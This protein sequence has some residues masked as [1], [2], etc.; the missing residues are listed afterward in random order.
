MRAPVAHVICRLGAPRRSRKLDH[1]RR[2]LRWV[3]G[4]VGYCL[5]HGCG[6]KPCKGDGGNPGV[7]AEHFGQR[8]ARRGL[9]VVRRHDDQPQRLQQVWRKV[10]G[11]EVVNVHAGCK[12]GAECRPESSPSDQ[13]PGPT[14][15]IP[16]F[17]NHSVRPR[18]S[19]VCRACAIP[20]LAA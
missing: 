4:K 13:S 6:A 19:T 18:R 20:P 16:R 1:F 15:A 5:E 2:G 3:Q 10:P 7:Q 14:H 8:I 12:C 11:V 17:C 9:E